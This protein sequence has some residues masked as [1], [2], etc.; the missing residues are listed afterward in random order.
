MYLYMFLLLFML[1]NKHFILQVIIQ[2]D[3]NKNT[4]LCNENLTK[5]LKIMIMQ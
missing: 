1:G 2:R 3:Y 4:I 5:N